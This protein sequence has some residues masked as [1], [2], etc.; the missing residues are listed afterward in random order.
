MDILYF[1]KKGGSKCKNFELRCS[2]RSI[3]KFGKN[4]GKVYIVGYCPDW[5]SDEVIKIPYETDNSKTKHKNL[6]DQLLYA[7]R[8]SDIGMRD[9]GE[10]LIAMDDHFYCR[11][12]DFDNYPFYSRIEELP[13]EIN[14]D[15][16][17]NKYT[18]SMINTRKF[19]EKFNL[20][21]D[22]SALHRGRHM[23]RYILEEMGDLNDLISSKDTPDV[24]GF[25]IA[26][27]YRKAKH[28]INFK[29]DKDLKIDNQ[30]I[31]RFLKIYK[32]DKKK[33]HIFSTKDFKEG[34]P[35]YF[36][37]KKIYKNKSKYEK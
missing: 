12:V 36:L 27:N 17:I 3:E 13:M 5:L 16:E 8:N 32:S 1:L 30:N 28:Y 25:A 15:K 21:T 18:Q 9:N 19:C 33:I 6:H 10:F 23:N 31:D 24:E 14:E 34:D 26:L 37:L 20:P 29:K 7:I 35:L 2:L 11:E 22:F 4:L